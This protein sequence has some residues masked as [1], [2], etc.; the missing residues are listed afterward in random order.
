MKTRHLLGVVL[1]FCVGMLHAQ[2]Q[3]PPVPVDTAVRIGKLENGLTYFIRYNNWPEHRAN[4][5]IAQKVGSIQEEENQRGLAHFLEHMAFNGSDHFKGNDL[6]EYCRSIGV[7]FGA[8]LNAYTSIDQTVYN[9]DNVPTSRQGSLDSCLLILR[10]WSTGLTLDPKEIDKERGVIHEEWRLSSTASSRMF[11]RNLPKLYPGSKYGLR[12]PIG[13]MSVVDSF[14][15]QQLR[16]YY[17]KWYHPSNQGIIVIG[18]VDLDHTEAM[19][20]KLFGPIKNP[21]P[22]AP[23]VSEPVPNTAEP[24]VIIDKDKEQR[25]SDV[26][27]MFKHDAFP[28]SLKQSLSYILYGYLKGAALNM[29][30]NRFTEAAQKP[31]CPYVGAGSS[32]GNYIF[33]KTKDAFSLYAQP[34]DMSLLAPSLKAVVVEARRAAQ[35]GFTSTE[36]ERYKANL[37]S[38]LEK[39]YSN[40]DK[41]NNTQFFNECLGYFLTNE[42][43][44]SIDYTYQTMKQLIPSI[45]VY[46][47]NQYMK[48]FVSENDSNV[49]VVNFNNE[50]EGNIYPTQDQFVK[51]LQSARQEQIT[52]YVD[53]VKNEPL[54][55]NKPKAGKIT[56]EKKNDKFGYTELKLSN[57]ATVVLKKTDFKKD[58][59]LL[60][61]EGFGGSSLYGP[62]DFLNTKMFDDVINIS[63]LANFSL[64]ELQKALAGKIANVNLSMKSKKMGVDGSSTPKDVETMMQML[65]LYFTKINKDQKSYDNLIGQYEV[66]LKNRALSPDVALSDSLT[67]TLYHHNPRTIPLKVEDLSKI[68]YDRILQMAKERTA[69][70][71][72]WTFT[73]IGNYD[74]NTIRPLICQYIA[75]LP[76]Q[77]KIVKGHRVLFLQKGEIDNTFYRKMETPKSTAYKIWYNEDMP[78]TLENDVKASMAGDILSMIYLKKIREEASAAYS[79]GAQATATIDDDYHVVQLLGYCPMKPEKK[80]LALNIMESAVH[81]L[82]K[83]VDPEMLEQ[84]RQVKLKQADDQAK[85][86][87]YWGNVIEVFRKYGIDTHTDYKKVISEQTPQMIADFMKEFLKSKNHI[88]VTMLPEEVKK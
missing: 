71:A 68:S 60:D 72:G 67:A 66:N 59:V 37:M 50:K 76:S 11:E 61:G 15:Y 14:S 49:V 4:F 30:N 54:I 39:E 12:Y 27:V 56:S 34:K 81:D 2:M 77:K 9:I 74:E 78:Y 79:C 69:N 43:M 23:I 3:M 65:Y 36:Y 26:E 20:K 53:N 52:A 18:D 24:I 21:V 10:D 64:T 40:K 82:S 86:N 31:D 41:R 1:L 84:V 70:A 73:I 22:S 32:D 35:F 80:D 29:L 17:E 75:S 33:A 55:K 85:T 83:T 25:T 46:M 42:P 38:N 88:T 62:N 19:I 13:L 8:D 47:V 57:G 6:I 51:A 87:G 48:E 45:P 7:E 16:D 63:G 44:P 58:Q 5:Y 28:D